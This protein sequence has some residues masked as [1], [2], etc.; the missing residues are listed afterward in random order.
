[1]PKHLRAQQ[2]FLKVS[3]FSSLSNSK[4]HQFLNIKL[5]IYINKFRFKVIIQVIIKNIIR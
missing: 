3:N 5:I 1:M 2:K 4:Y